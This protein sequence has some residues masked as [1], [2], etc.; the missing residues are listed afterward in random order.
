SALGR[1]LLHFI[2]EGALIAALLGVMLVALRRAS[3][4]ARYLAACAAMLAMIA[5]FAVTAIG[6]GP[7]STRWAA[8]VIATFALRDAVVR[9]GATGDAA[10]MPFGNWAVVAWLAG[11]TILLVRRAGGWLRARRML[12]RAT[13]SAEQY[14]LERLDRLR[15]RMGIGRAVAL[16]ES[17]LADSPAVMGWLR[18]MILTP[19][20]WLMGL[21][22]EQAEAVLLHELAHVR[23]H[24]YLVNLMQSVVED[25]L[26]YHPAVWWVGR[27]MRCEREN[28]CDD[29]VVA[30]GGDVRNYART[31]ASLEGLRAGEPALAASGG[32]LADR[33]RRLVR[34]PAGPRASAAPLMLS[35]ALVCAGAAA[36]PAWQSRPPKPVVAPAPPPMT[37]AQQEQRAAI[38]QGMERFHE[39]RGGVVQAEHSSDIANANDKYPAGN[40][41]RWR[42]SPDPGWKTDRGR[43]HIIDAPYALYASQDQT[44]ANPSNSPPVQA[45]NLTTP[46]HVQ[47]NGDSLYEDKGAS[48][49]VG[50]KGATLIMVHANEGQITLN[51]ITGHDGSEEVV[52]RESAHTEAD[53]LKLVALS[54]GLYRLVA[55]TSGSSYAD[56]VRRTGI[57]AQ[58]ENLRG[59][60][61]AAR[62][63]YTDNH[64]QLVRLQRELAMMEA[65]RNETEAK[66]E[67]TN[68]VSRAQ[69]EFRVP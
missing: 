52:L 27:V 17:A 45:A 1:A 67:R 55:E 20:G 29:I 21:P 30:M 31:L 23:R 39:T 54:P 24:D 63:M 32:Q 57:Q 7:A 64:P 38:I 3:A 5:S 35:L 51:R 28:C 65:L 33:I 59:Q 56:R 12:A 2:W 66:S 41:P 62:E 49:R 18:P 43:A 47:S 42:W 16:V 9:T 6:T 50:E 14:W 15:E 69:V 68:A 22:A 26:F 34:P 58:L 10:T 37:Q 11:V 25:L 40:P 19:A 53:Y 36:L 8:P 48:V 61:A 46:T 13:V 44:P 4:Q 60:V